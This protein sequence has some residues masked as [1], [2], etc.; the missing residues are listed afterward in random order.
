MSADRY[1][2]LTV[3]TIHR[4]VASQRDAVVRAGELVAD[5]LSQGGRLWAFGTGH[6]HMI[7]EELWS[8]AGGLDSV[9]P[10]FDAGLDMYDGPWRSMVQERLP[11]LAETLI[12][13]R[14]LG[15]KD[16]MIIASNS[17][18]NTVP[19]EMAELAHERGATVIALT[20]L[21]HSSAVASRAPS[22]K[23][24]FELADLVI[25]NCGVVGD[26]IVPIGTSGAMSGATS[27]VVGALL[28]QAIVV[29]AA[30]L[31]VERG[32]PAPLL[33]SSN[34]DAPPAGR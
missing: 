33:L 10:V 2:E 28:A 6:S 12:G 30:T 21:T 9:I 32:E 18:R 20:S 15:D 11:G 25:D 16:V 31:V 8:R 14:D 26:A 23:R 3:E 1:F 7:A 5:A 17:G 4:A 22:G 13:D 24:L 19:V 27:T 34:V 29:Q